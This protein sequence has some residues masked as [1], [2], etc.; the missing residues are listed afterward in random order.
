MKIGAAIAIGGK[1]EIDRMTASSRNLRGNRRRASAYAAN[2][3]TIN[4]KTVVTVVT[5]RLF[6]SAEVKSPFLKTEE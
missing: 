6:R 4:A 2:E 3:P 1:V 5:M